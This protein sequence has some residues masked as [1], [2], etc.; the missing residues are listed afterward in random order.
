LTGAFLAAGSVFGQDVNTLGSKTAGRVFLPL[1]SIP[2][3]RPLGAGRLPLAA[4]TG[5]PIEGVTNI[6]IFVPAVQVEPP[7]TVG[8]AS[9]AGYFTE[10]PASIACIYGLTTTNSRECNPNKVHE[11]TT[12]GSRVIAIVDAFDAPNAESDLGVFSQRFGL[13]QAN[14][15]KVYATGVKPDGAGVA[16]DIK[17]GWEVEISLDIEWAHAMAPNAKIILVEAAS[18]SYKDL[19]FA[20]QKASEQVSNEGGGEVSNSWGGSEFGGETDSDN[21]FV[22]EGIVYLGATGD[23]YYILYPSSSPNI[24]AAGGTSI[25]RDADGS[26]IS[27]IPWWNNKGGTGAGSSAFEPRPNFQAAVSSIVGNWRGVPD[28]V[29]VADPT[30]GGVWVYDSTNAMASSNKGWLSVGGTSAA[31]PIV[32]ALINKANHFA[33]S[34]AAELVTIYSHLNT[35]SFTDITTGKCGPGQFY[36]ANAGWDYCSG[37]GSPNGVDGL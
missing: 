17:K 20:E 5:E 26:F 16:D 8:P 25:Q 28:L 13:P 31:T 18:N 37:V 4:G 14:F 33:A 1:S 11:N 9:V 21:Q 10:T 35:K 22:R 32:A 36:S 19:V 15:Q 7:T 23:N 2:S 24:V 12:G 3:P 34:S 30:V 6:A 27:E 29:A